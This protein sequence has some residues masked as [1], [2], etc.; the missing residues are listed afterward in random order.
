MNNG[1]NGFK[2]LRRFPGSKEYIVGEIVNENEALNIPIRNRLA[3]EKSGYIEFLAE[4]AD[5]LGFAVALKEN[6]EL[7][8]KNDALSEDIK[9]ILEE[10]EEL[11]AKNDALSEDI[12]SI[13]EENEELLKEISELKDDSLIKEIESLKAEN[14]TL[15]NE[16]AELKNET[17]S[18]AKQTKNKKGAE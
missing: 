7:S 6:E 5:K 17:N 1:E 12:K 18:E 3:L 4:P 15:N 16:I 11:S 2:V 9:S 8:A 14:N 13:L 10:N